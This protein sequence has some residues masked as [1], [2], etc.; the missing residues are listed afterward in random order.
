MHA[1]SEQAARAKRRWREHS[2][3]LKPQRRHTLAASMAWIEA[4]NVHH[5]AVYQTMPLRSLRTTH[6]VRER[7]DFGSPD[8]YFLE[9]VT[10][11]LHH[12]L[13]QPMR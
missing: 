5:L 1:M 13:Q 9:R 12:E 11:E 10:A 8:G 6:R 2:P 3:A 7:T 4:S